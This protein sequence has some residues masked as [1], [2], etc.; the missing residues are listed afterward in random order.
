M[1]LT[2][3]IIIKPIKRMYS[4]EIMKNMKK[5]TGR[6]RKIKERNGFTI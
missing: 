1:G 6:K 2:N 3:K 5:K 4:W